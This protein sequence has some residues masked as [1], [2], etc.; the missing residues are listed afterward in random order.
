MDGKFL[1]IMAGYDQETSQKLHSFRQ[2]VLNAG[3][4]GTQ[5]DRIP[6]HITL[7]TADPSREEELACAVRLAAKSSQ[8][9]AV[10]FNHAGIF[11][12]GKVLFLAPDT[13]RALLDLKEH[14]GP[15]YNWTPHSTMLI[16]SPEHVLQAAPVLMEGFSAFE[17]RVTHI[18]LYEF[19]P[20]RHIL[21]VELG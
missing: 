9:F 16:D 21:S 14:F 11:Q 8:P 5:S 10:T 18:H 20:T 19:W 6:H 4:R 15:S 7:G 17:G 1:C 3:F 13:S 12:G 2:K